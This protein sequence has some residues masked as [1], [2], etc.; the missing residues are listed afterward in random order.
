VVKGDYHA[1]GRLDRWPGPPLAAVILDC[2]STLVDLEGIEWLAAGDPEVTRWTEEAMAGHRRLEDV[3]AAR[4]ARV[5]PSRAQVEALGRHYRTRLLPDAAAAV[6]AW[7]ALGKEVWILSAAPAA[8]LAPL[9]AALGVP[10]ERTAGVPLRFDATGAYQGFDPACPLVR[11]D[12]K[13]AWLAAANP[14]RPRVVVGDGSTDAAARQ[15]VDAF[16]AFIGVRTRPT[17]VAAA[18]AALAHWAAVLAWTTTPA[19]RARL[20]SSPWAEVLA[21]GEVFLKAA[22]WG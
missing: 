3:Y 7:H 17:V 6:A 9:A 22:N 1:G 16:V 21:R 15:A 12:G 11:A 5:R 13:A 10:P 2:D 14:P 19:E 8:A 18:D 20:L 4:L